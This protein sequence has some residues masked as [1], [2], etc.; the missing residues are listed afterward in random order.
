MALT[1]CKECEHEVSVEAPLCPACG[2]PNP[3]ADYRGQ[4]NW[5][6]LA[7]PSFGRLTWSTF[8]GVLLWSVLPFLA[9]GIWMMIVGAALLGS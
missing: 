8:T 2:T 7:G 4:S 3:A 9:W 6:E 1:S 5:R